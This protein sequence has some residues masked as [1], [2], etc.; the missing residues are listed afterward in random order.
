MNDAQFKFFLS[1]FLALRARIEDET[2]PKLENELLRLQILHLKRENEKQNETLHEEKTKRVKLE[3]QIANYHKMEVELTSERNVLKKE[4]DFK[5][6]ELN[7]L[8]LNYGKVEKQLNQEQEK[9]RGLRK[10]FGLI[11]RNLTELD[12]ETSRA[13]E[14]M[15]NGLSN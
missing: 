8:K 4:L 15:K 7:E 11:H 10:S 14:E 2:S 6:K 1:E 13:M 5:N 12:E 3:G 9:R